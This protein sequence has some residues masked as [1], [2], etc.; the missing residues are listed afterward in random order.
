[1]TI[2]DGA[3]RSWVCNVASVAR[4][5]CCSGRVP[6]RTA[7]A[8]VSGASPPASSRSLMRRRLRTPI[9]TTMVPPTRAIASQSTSAEALVGSSWP[10]TTVRLVEEYRIVTGMPAAAGAAS[11]EVIPGTTS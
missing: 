11:A 10:V 5:V 3:A 4:T 2:V 1:M 7:A 6:Q 8:G 9:S